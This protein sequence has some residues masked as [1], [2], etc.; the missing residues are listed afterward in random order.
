MSKSIFKPELPLPHYIDYA[1]GVKRVDDK[2]GPQLDVGGLLQDI[3]WQMIQQGRDQL[4]QT[5]IKD[6]ASIIN[7]RDRSTDESMYDEHAALR[8]TNVGVLLGWA[9]CQK[10]LR[11]HNLSSQGMLRQAIK[12]C[13]CEGEDR[14]ETLA[15]SAENLV[16]I[17]GKGL[18]LLGEEAETVEYWIDK[19]E[20]DISLQRLTKVGLGLMLYQANAA[21]G[22]AD[23][24]KMEQE[25]DKVNWND[26]ISFCEG[27]SSEGKV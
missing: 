23:L 16:D 10:D 7:P 11:Q 15:L 12:D 9:I 5:E 25:A 6:L 1:A 2:L 22:E 24:A 27:G 14:P 26:L 19:A 20:P 13:A 18:A 3:A 8:A 4:I 21:V 17:A